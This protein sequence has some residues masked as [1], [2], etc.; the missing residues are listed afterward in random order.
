MYRVLITGVIH[1]SVLNLLRKES[2]IEIQYSPDLPYADIVQ[3]IEPFH[4]ILS[5]S[6]TLINRELIERALEMKVIVRAGVGVGNIDVEYATESGILVIN[7]PSKNT[8]FA[9]ELTIGLML[10]TVLMIV[11]A[12][13]E[14][15]AQ[16]WKR[17]RFSGMELLNK[18]LGIIGFGNVDHRVARYARAFEMKVQ[19]FDPDIAFEVFERHG[20]QKA[21]WKTL[22]STSDFM[23]L[24]VPLN[25]VT[26]GMIAKEELELM[27]A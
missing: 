18:T 21:D 24:H 8:N 7:T 4:C 17:H 14:M 9:S 11:L 12:H 19:A 6:E 16:S 10:S 26:R 13:Q 22:I 27:K 3:I 25:D 5:R 20:V 2:D 1:S 23:S 15:H